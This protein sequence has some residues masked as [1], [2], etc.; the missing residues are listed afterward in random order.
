[1][2]Y[3]KETFD[4][5]YLLVSND[6]GERRAQCEHTTENKMH[7]TLASLAFTLGTSVLSTYFIVVLYMKDEA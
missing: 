4:N 5:L 2:G 1:M 3:R 7:G 6:Y